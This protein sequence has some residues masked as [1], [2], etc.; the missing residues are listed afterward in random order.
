M[1]KSPIRWSLTRLVN[2]QLPD[3]IIGQIDNLP[4]GLGEVTAPALLMRNYLTFVPFQ[5]E[6]GLTEK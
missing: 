4:K 1:A 6:K 3:P 5:C 2:G